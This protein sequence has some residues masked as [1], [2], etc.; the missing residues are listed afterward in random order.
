[1]SGGPS[2]RGSLSISLS[3]NFSS[4]E[5][6]WE[7]RWQVPAE[8]GALRGQ[9][10]QTQSGLRLN[11]RRGKAW[12]QGEREGL[13]R[14]KPSDFSIFLLRVRFLAQPT[15]RLQ[16]REMCAVSGRNSQK[17]PLD[18]VAAPRSLLSAF[19]PFLEGSLGALSGKP[20]VSLR[21]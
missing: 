21:Q 7:R 18:G 15:G 12:R 13:T 8:G 9:E 2:W 4:E 6:W 16:T 19:S 14:G 10:G 17:G 20:T 1:M 5:R 3:K 11:G